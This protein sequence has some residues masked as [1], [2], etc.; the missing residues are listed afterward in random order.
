MTENEDLEAQI[1]KYTQIML[2]TSVTGV[3]EF[4]GH[5]LK[6]MEDN[7]AR[8]GVIELPFSQNKIISL[9]GEELFRVEHIYD[10]G[11][12]HVEIRVGR[13]YMEERLKG[14]MKNGK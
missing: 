10:N 8:I 7:L 3:F 13:R 6:W 1:I 2:D 11:E 9:D 4:L 14:V 5:D 12:W